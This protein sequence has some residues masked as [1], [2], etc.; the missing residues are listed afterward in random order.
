MSQFVVHATGLEFRTSGLRARGRRSCSVL[1]ASAEGY[2]GHLTPP[3]QVNS[4]FSTT[5][6]ASTY[7]RRAKKAK[8]EGGMRSS[9]SRRF[10]NK[11]EMLSYPNY[12]SPALF[13]FTTT[14]LLTAEEGMPAPVWGT[15]C[16]VSNGLWVGTAAAY[17]PSTGEHG[18]VW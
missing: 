1:R 6:T 3:L 12:A 11:E 14:K 10:P 13:Q 15:F 8:G 9:A 5:L 17:N 18:R 7:E 4:H 2:G 16:G